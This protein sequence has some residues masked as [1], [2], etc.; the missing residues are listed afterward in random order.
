VSLINEA[1]RKARQAASEHDAKQPEGAFQP[2]RSY[3]SRRSGRR[4]GV[5]AVMVVAVAA[6][7]VGAFAAWWIIGDRH[8]TS[9]VAMESPP[10]PVTIAAATKTP[11]PLPSNKEDRSSAAQP[12]VAVARMATQVAPTEVV[13]QPEEE[14]AGLGPADDTAN[15]TVSLSDGERVFEIEAE[16]GYASL[17]LGY[18]IAR[19][20]NPF[21]EINGVDVFVGSEIEGFVVEAIETDRVILRDDKGILV[22]R[23]P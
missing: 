21:A 5:F 14:T 18:I 7:A 9:P 2:A 8:D 22:L 17:N 20:E 6:A 11:E 16:L 15:D 3:P 19:S 1:L 10:K 4:S 12:P 13:P 23:V